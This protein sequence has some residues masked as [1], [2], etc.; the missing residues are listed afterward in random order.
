MLLSTAVCLNLGPSQIRKR[1][2]LGLL[3][4]Q[5]GLVLSILFVWL[6]VSDIVRA[7]VFIPYFFAYL[8]IIQSLQK[9]CVFL[10]FQGKQNLDAGNET[11]TEDLLRKKLKS[12]SIWIIILATLLA[13]L[14]TYLTLVIHPEIMGMPIMNPG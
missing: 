12:R 5:L 6:N 4:F 3:S 13:L 2:L 1:R 11:V 14:C 10:A 8:G 9:T 7:T